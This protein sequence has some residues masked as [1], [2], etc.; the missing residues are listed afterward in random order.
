MKTEFSKKQSEYWDSYTKDIDYLELIDIPRA[1]KIEFAFLKR[2]L[3]KIKDK[4]ILDLGCGTGKFGLK[5]A[6]QAKEVIGID[7]SKSSV[8]IANRTA[9]KN[10]IRNFKGVVGDFKDKGYKNYF[11]T[12]LAVNLIHHA[13]DLDEI[14]KHVAISLKKNGKLI[15]FEMNSMNLLFIPFL[16]YIGQAK[17]HLTW[18][19]LRSNLFSL[20]Y[21]LAKNGYRIESV[22]RWSWLPT[23][24]YNKS[25]VFKSINETL[26]KIPLINL[27]TAFNIFVCSFDP[28]RD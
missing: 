10:N 22:K 13:D 12:V 8:G 9:K 11:D 18:Q 20:K 28:Q 7:I 23:S 15:V 24:L 5:L 14:L 16:I 1:E 26:N 25:L 19:Y 21:V 17:S 6:A 2:I 4:T 3:G 27:F